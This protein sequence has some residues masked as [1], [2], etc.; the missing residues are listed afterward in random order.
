MS[1]VYAWVD[2][3]VVQ[4]HYKVCVQIEKREKLLIPKINSL[5]KHVGHCKTLVLMPKVKTGEHYFLKTIA[6]LQ[7]RNYILVRVLK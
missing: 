5:W 1:I 3:K 7:T 6:M 2:G 4:V